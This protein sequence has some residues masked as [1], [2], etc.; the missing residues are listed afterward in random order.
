[1]LLFTAAMLSAFADE[2]MP[3]VKDYIKQANQQRKSALEKAERELKEAAADSSPK[4]SKK[5]RRRF[6]TNNQSKLQSL[7]LTVNGLKS[8]SILP[9]PQ[10][11]MENLEVGRVGVIPS[12]GRVVSVEKAGVVVS[13]ER[14][15]SGSAKKPG[16]PVVVVIR[17]LKE[18]SVEAAAEF[19]SPEVFAVVGKVEAD[20]VSRMV[21]RQYPHV[22]KAIME[23]EDEWKEAGVKKKQLKNLDP[24]K[25]PT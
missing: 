16:P 12:V 9:T 21:L 5:S 23:W 2:T 7:K 24:A 13:F 4:P 14:W 20:G 3:S 17:G 6:L 22:G 8:G 11:E 10:L 18:G 25:P 15:G 19:S 1:M